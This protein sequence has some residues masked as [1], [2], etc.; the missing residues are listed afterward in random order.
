MHKED[1]MKRSALALVAVV[2]VSSLVLAANPVLISVKVASAPTIDGV[3]SEG[4]WASAPALSFKT[5]EA[6]APGAGNKSESTVV[7]KSVYTGDAV[8]FLVVWDDPTYSIDRQRWVFD[9][10]KWSKEDQTPLEKGGANTNYEDKVALMWGINSP[11]FE[12]EGPWALYRDATEAAKAGYQRP[13]KT[14]P[15]GE[16]LDMWHFKLV[17]TGFTMP[18]QVDDQYVNDTF[19]ATKAPEAGRF[20]DPGTGGYYNNER[21]LK[22]ADGTTVKIPKYAMKNGD[23]NAFILT[24]EMI[25]KGDAVELSDANAIKFAKGAHL[26][27]IIGRVFTGSR[28]DITGKAEWKDGKYTLEFG[29]KLDTGDAEH[30]VE[31]KDLGKTYFFGVATFD[32][33][34]IKHAVSDLLEF[35]F[36]R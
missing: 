25:D 15:K 2:G 31:F 13:V 12:K 16:T 30:D 33:T 22:M 3:A 36:Q 35:K 4:F 21:D 32:N 1:R 29:R 19:D 9:G 10:A 20:S 14:A 7:M 8:F 6:A 18:G 34:Q 28:G 26:P 17:R 11:T 24:Q 27:A 23:T 5:I